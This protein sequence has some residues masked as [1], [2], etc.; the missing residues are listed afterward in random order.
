MHT[1]SSLSRIARYAP[2]RNCHSALETKSKIWQSQLIEPT[3]NELPD[4]RI[5][6]PVYK[7]T[8]KPR[9]TIIGASRAWRCVAESNRPG[10]FCR[11]E[12]KPLIQRTGTSFVLSSWMIAGRPSLDSGCKSTT[13]FSFPQTFFHLFWRN[14]PF[15]FLISRI[16]ITFAP[17]LSSQPKR[18]PAKTPASQASA[19]GEIGRRARLR[20]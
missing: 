2:S 7:L 15:S 16:I 11:P 20:I 12:T 9:L 18:R 8:I 13:F 1:V 4:K 14:T 6:H 3:I 5:E 19:C 10:R 17:L